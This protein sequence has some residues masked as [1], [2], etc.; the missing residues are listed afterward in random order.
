MS[1]YTYRRIL[2]TGGAGF[3]GS[4]LALLFKQHF[5]DI[6]VTA[7]DNLMRRGSELNLPVLKTNGISFVHGD[8]RCRDDFKQT[9]PFDLLI[10]CAAEPS[11]HAGNSGSPRTVIDINLNGTLNCLEAAREQDA[12]V[13]FLSTSR[14]YPIAA[15]RA[16]NTTET[17]TRFEL[18]HAQ[19]LPGVSAKGITEGFPLEGS[20]SFYGATKLSA[21]LFLGEYVYNYGMRGLINRCGIL[22][23]PRQMGRVDQGV[24]TLWLARHIYKKPL[25][26]TGFGGSGKQ[27]RDLLHIGDLFALILAQIKAPACWNGCI[28]NVG[29]GRDVSVSLLELTSLCQDITGHTV[30]VSREQETA[31][32][33]IPVYLTDSTRAQQQFNWTTSKG[34]ADTLQDIADWIKTNQQELAPILS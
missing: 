14:V 27:V 29:G 24:I 15:L 32:V 19:T 25:R 33:D 1:G 34:V 21:E 8:V 20:R 6:Q 22:T 4:S 5:G 30:P 3:A 18:T 17:A 13:L 26:Y 12:A 31:S 7:F 2:I 28:Y 16:L 10:D 11:V 23:G 9:G